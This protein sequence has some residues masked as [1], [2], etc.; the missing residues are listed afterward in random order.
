MESN[1]PLKGIFFEINFRETVLPDS[2]IHK[3][4]SDARDFPDSDNH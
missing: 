1:I 3:K 2:D 4:I